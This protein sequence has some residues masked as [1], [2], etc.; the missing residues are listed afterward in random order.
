MIQCL[1]G[2]PSFKCRTLECG[3]DLDVESIK[4]PKE[5]LTVVSCLNELL[6]MLTGRTSLWYRL[7][8]SDLASFCSRSSY[9]RLVI[10]A[11]LWSFFPRPLYEC[12]KRQGNGTDLLASFGGASPPPMFA[13]SRAYGEMT[14]A[15]WLWMLCSF[16]G[17]ESLAGR[18]ELHQANSILH[19]HLVVL[20]IRVHV[21]SLQVPAL[22]SRCSPSI[23]IDL[24]MHIWF[25]GLVA[26]DSPWVT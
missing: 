5:N 12:V 26:V 8:S 7:L 18:W 10:C 21:Y 24:Y 11:V 9:L 2:E 23:T 13:Q 22:P 4:M 15:G 17:G 3:T 16:P 1:P 14:R 6:H 20:V 19:F 25:T